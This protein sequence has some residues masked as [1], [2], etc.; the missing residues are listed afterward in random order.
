MKNQII[1]IIA[2]IALLSVMIWRW[3]TADDELKNL[4]FYLLLIITIGQ[5]IWHAF[6]DRK[7]KN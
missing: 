3:E 4:I 1:G 5:N 7:D 2:F 6:K